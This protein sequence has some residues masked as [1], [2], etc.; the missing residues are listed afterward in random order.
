MLWEGVI[1]WQK[2]ILLLNVNLCGNLSAIKPFWNVENYL[3][4]V[5]HGVWTSWRK[6]LSVEKLKF[7]FS[8]FILF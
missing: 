5:L 7:D 6:L 3:I 2:V 1:K 8:S 4:R